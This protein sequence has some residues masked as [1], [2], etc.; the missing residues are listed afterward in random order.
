MILLALLPILAFGGIFFLTFNFQPSCDWRRSFV[1][2]ALL[3]GCYLVAITE[4]LSLVHGIT[5]W[6]LVITWLLPMIAAVGYGFLRVSVTPWQR[7]KQP[8]SHRDTEKSDWGSRV[9]LLGV[10]AILIITALVAWVTPPQTYDSLNYHMPR[11]AHWAQEHA[12][13]HYATGIAEQNVISPGAELVV[14]HFYV[15]TNG[16]QLANIP[17]WLSLLGSIIVASWVAALLGADRRG[18]VL[19]AV[20]AA[21]IPMGIV[22][23]SST[24][25]DSVAAFWTLCVAAEALALLTGPMR[26]AGL[27][28]DILAAGLALLTKPTTSVFVLPFGALVGWLLWQRWKVKQT[29]VWGAIALVL[30]VG[31]N[32]GHLIRNAVTYGNPLGDRARL[33]LHNNEVRTLQGI[34]SNLIRNVALH[35][36][37]PWGRVNRAVYNTVVKIHEG[38]GLAVDDPR[39]TSAGPYPWMGVRTDENIAGNLLHALLIL[40]CSGVALIARKRLGNANLTYVLLSAS[41]F[42]LFSIL[43]KWQVYGSRYHMPFFVLFA[44]AIAYAL[45]ALLRPRM[46]WVVA[47]FL[48]VFTY[49]WLFS[50][51]SRPLIPTS[52]RSYPVSI[53]AESREKLYFANVPYLDYS[54][55]EIVARI[56]DADCTQV[57]LSISGMGAEYPLWALLDAPRRPGLQMEWLISGPSDQYSKPDFQPCAVICE[58]CEDQ[59]T[60]RDLPL[61]YY[62]DTM[63]LYLAP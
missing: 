25:T 54:Y 62:F 63:R 51:D 52:N 30:V 60:F 46:G 42:V 24:M 61:A 23:A 13:V 22:Q 10:A 14:L 37:T 27:V 41:T 1:R 3:W 21:T 57:G 17:A 12:V 47:L 56:K 50:I 16:D 45:W 43:F 59:A 28:F 5:A 19:A 15:L 36:G 7:W 6:G 38:L 35:S 31:I 55:H 29:L 48:I 4:L 44:P 34:T 32:A 53:L 8:Q 40:W 39:T 20:V 2:A 49:P 11:V 58:G 9:L 26:R 18:Q 33:S